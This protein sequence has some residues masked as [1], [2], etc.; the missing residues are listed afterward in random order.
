M[1][2]RAFSQIEV[3]VAVAVLSVGL[4]ALFAAFSYSL[5]VTR[6]AEERAEAASLNQRLIELVRSET[7]WAEALPVGLKDAPE[8]RRALNAPPLQSEVFSPEE[9]GKYRRNLNVTRVSD[10]PDDYRFRLWHIRARLFWDHKGSPRS[11]FF[12]GYHRQP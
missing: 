11:C 8:E 6:Y 9:L 10:D 5:R 12:E 3:L 4:L 2:R 1:K 7:E